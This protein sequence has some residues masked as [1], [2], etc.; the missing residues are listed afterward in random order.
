MFGLFSKKQ[1]VSA[2]PIYFYNT[3]SGQKEE[4]KPLKEGTA[5]MY[6]CGP[7]VYDH[8][9]IG[10]LRAYLLPDLIKRVLFYN[11]YR[12]EHTINFTDFGHLSDDGDAGEDKMMKA[13]KRDGKPI[14]LEAMRELAQIYIDSFKVD[15][16][17]LRNL[18][19]STYAPASDFVK[20]QI[21]LIETLVGKGYA[22][23]TSDGVYFEVAKFPTY[24]VL[25]NVDISKIREGARVEANPEKKHPADFAL[26]KKGDLGWES[27]W[28]KGFPGWHIECTAMIFATLGKQIDI[29]TG[30]E[31][32][33]YTHHNGEIAQAEACTGKAYVNYWLHNAFVTIEDNKI[34][35]SEGNGITLRNLKDRGFAPEDYRYWLLTSHYR[36]QANFTFD[37]LTASKKTLFRL[38]RHLFE[39]YKNQTGI[40]NETYDK[41]FIA[42]I[43]DDLD[44]PKAIALIWD[45]I[46]DSSVSAADKVTTIK[47]WDDVLGLGLNDRA[48]DIIKELGV[49]DMDEVPE[50][51]QQLIE[52]RE[53]ARVLRNWD[54]ADRLREAINLKGFTL[55]DTPEGPKVSRV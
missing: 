42:A 5:K 23:E 46:K 53:A 8:I 9:H 1:E 10:N 39:E 26:W 47:K 28:G 3:A 6:S 44:T 52:E 7:T 22:Y 54:E 4:F 43:N 27:N 20:E 24:G 12:V 25:G 34:A 55:E 17:L 29:H 19:A 36:T 13:L 15:N 49:I 38:K 50:D 48:E 45:L 16:E 31:D 30:G 51:V 11:G 2:D 32:L 18:P 37:A 35:K 14:S 40:L 41:R 33:K 21:A